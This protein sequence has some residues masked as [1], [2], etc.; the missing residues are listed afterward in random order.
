MNAFVFDNLNVCNLGNTALYKRLWWSVF[1]DVR[2]RAG[3][4]ILE[5]LSHALIALLN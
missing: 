4:V 5:V 3:D 2:D 1:G